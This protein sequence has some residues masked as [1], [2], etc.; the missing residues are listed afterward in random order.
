MRPAAPLG[1]QGPGSLRRVGTAVVALPGRSASVEAR[2]GDRLLGHGP[3]R[4][5]PRSDARAGRSPA[6]ARNVSRPRRAGGAK[7]TVRPDCTLSSL[8]IGEI[9][10]KLPL[11]RTKPTGGTSRK[12]GDGRRRGVRKPLRER[13]FGSALAVARLSLRSRSVCASAGDA[14]GRQ[15]RKPTENSRLRTGCLQTSNQGRGPNPCAGRESE[16]C[17]C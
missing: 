7:P 6:L 11:F 16:R 14:P 5:S 8:S 13:R 1:R 15:P 2:Q 10:A 12:V 9:S 3:R 4:S 17:W